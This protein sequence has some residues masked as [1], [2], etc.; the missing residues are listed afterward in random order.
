MPSLARRAPGE[1][2]WERSMCVYVYKD[3]YIY[4]RMPSRP[5]PPLVQAYGLLTQPSSLF[6]LLIVAF[7]W[8]YT[9]ARDDEPVFLGSEVPPHIRKLVLVAATVFIVTFTSRQP[10]RRPSTFAI[11]LPSSSEP[12]LV[13][14]SKTGSVTITLSSSPHAQ[15]EPARSSNPATVITR[16]GDIFRAVL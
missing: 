2:A 12:H 3:I 8:R 11:G 9:L 7:A 16:E 6:V 14:F 4:I 10:S 13:V 5:R 1:W 15:A